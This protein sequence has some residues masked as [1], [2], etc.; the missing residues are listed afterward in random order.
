MTELGEMFLN[1]N[2]PTKSFKSFTID[3][4]DFN[5]AYSNQEKPLSIHYT[6]C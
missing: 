6:S 4:D 3:G 2:I 5:E 1:G